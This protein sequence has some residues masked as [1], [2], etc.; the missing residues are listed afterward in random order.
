VE[1]W[2]LVRRLVAEGVPRRQ[3]A[4]DLGIGRST[5]DRA[6]ASDGPPKYE[7]QAV[8]TSFSP[9]EARVSVIL[10]E[11]PEMPATVIAERVGW[12]GSITW[13]R[14]NVRRL[15]PEHRRPD[16]ADRLTWA[17]GDAAQCDLWFPPAKIPLEDGTRVSPPVLVVVAAH[18]RFVTAVMIPT[19]K[20]ED[21]LLG[22]WELI[23]QLGRVPRRLIWDNEA[24]IGQ[25]G[26]LAQG[27]AAFAGTLATRVVQLRPYDPES[28]GIVERRNG[29]L[30]TSFLPGR[31]FTSPADFNTQLSGWL[32]LANQRMLRTIKARPLDLIQADRAAMLAL[33]PVVMGLGWRE[34]V[35]L[36]R[37]Y[38]VRLDS[39]D[40]S[41]DPT[42]I[43]RMVDV[44]A[45]LDRV[46][47]RLDGRIVADHAR[48]WARGST[49]A[50]PAH[51]ETAKLLRQQF[52]Q[53][54]PAPADDLHRDLADYDRAFGL[55]GEVA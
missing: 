54:R 20:T 48:V 32:E 21:L 8:A 10:S 29:W 11:Y 18:S 3:V 6:L 26:R 28:K 40:Y 45:D 44:T 13:F 35:R 4:R 9:F 16:P 27:V 22:S 52:Q 51:V 42:A 49:V 31:S 47:V 38:Y 53:P 33:P 43:G 14:D 55:S 36:G 41:V 17:P 15:R 50:D 37:D 1:D 2:A 7:R 46:R 39:S 24:G 5:V 30:E 12:Q 34:H 23:R 25:R 19:R